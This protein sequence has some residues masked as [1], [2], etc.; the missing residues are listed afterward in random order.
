MRRF[1]R[2]LVRILAVII[3]VIA[4]RYLFL[5]HEANRYNESIYENLKMEPETAKEKESASG[6]RYDLEALKKANPDCVG[7]VEIPG[8]DIYYP[9]LYS[10]KEDG[11]YYMKRNFY[12]EPDGRGSIFMDFRCDHKKPSTN[13]VLYGHR[14]RNDQMFAQLKGYKEKSFWE[15]HQ[16]IY[17]TDE[18]GTGT[19][20]IF[21]AYLS[22]DPE[23]M[24]E[25]QKKYQLEFIDAAGEEEITAFSEAVRS[26]S[27]Y[28]TGIKTEP[29]DCFLTLRTCDYAVSNGRISVV[30]RLE[31]A[32]DYK[33]EVKTEEESGGVE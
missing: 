15:E 27:Y 20:R 21:A 31:Q 14:M 5:E 10:E 4:A 8:T 12:E 19:Y 6:P 25:N 32:P 26:W 2:Y 3:I 29:Q 7:I 24:D 18:R 9:V 1:I 33:T 30:A 11:F 23:N 16:L 22:K 17:Y 28:N 13:L